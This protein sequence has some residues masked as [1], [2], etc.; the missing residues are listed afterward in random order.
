MECNAIGEIITKFDNVRPYFVTVS[1]GLKLLLDKPVCDLTPVENVLLELVIENI[2]IE[3]YKNLFSN[4]SNC[5]RCI[6]L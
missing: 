6:L 3:L 5:K 2:E 4:E 1:D